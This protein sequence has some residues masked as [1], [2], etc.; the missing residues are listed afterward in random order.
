MW[1]RYDV[2]RLT[3]PQNDFDGSDDVWS[4]VATVIAEKKPLRGAELV[5]ATTVNEQLDSKVRFRWNSELADLST[6][7]RIK[8]NGKLFHIYSVVNV[9]DDDQWIECQVLEH[10]SRS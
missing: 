4:K 9:N 5:A 8:R 1:R 10:A 6:K 2:E 7:D 3:K